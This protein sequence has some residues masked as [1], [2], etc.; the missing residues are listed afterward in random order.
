LIIFLFSI[1]RSTYVVVIQAYAKRAANTL[2]GVRAKRAAQHERQLAK[3]AKKK[4]EAAAAKD[5]KKAEKPERAKK[6][7][8]AKLR[9]VAAIR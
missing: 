8:Q 2:F 3:E 6:P 4:A 9:K 5:K 1:S 7:E